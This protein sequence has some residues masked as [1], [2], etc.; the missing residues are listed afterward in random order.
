MANGTGLIGAL[1]T[2]ETSVVSFSFNV[3]KD[4]PGGRQLN[5]TLD[6][7]SN[8]LQD[9]E[10]FTLLV[11]SE[12]ITLAINNVGLSLTNF[13]RIGFGQPFDGAGGIGFTFNNGPSL[14]FEGAIIAGTGPDRISNAA[15]GKDYPRDSAL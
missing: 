12:F 3:S 6:I 14:L 5:F 8:T 11:E 9:K 10:I 2:L 13:G 1:G 7:S 15:R 4:A